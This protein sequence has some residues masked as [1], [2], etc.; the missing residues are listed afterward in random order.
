MSA[1]G[2]RGCLRAACAEVQTLRSLVPGHVRDRAIELLVRRYASGK[3]GAGDVLRGLDACLGQGRCVEC[4]A[5]WTRA[6][7]AVQPVPLALT[8]WACDHADVMSVEALRLLLRT[9]ASDAAIS[10]RVRRHVGRL[11]SSPEGLVALMYDGAG[12]TWWSADMV[13]PAIRKYLTMP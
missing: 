13:Q 6:V 4:A 2:V 12:L 3:R 7:K 9:A 5:L 1:S 11:T 10:A 8:A